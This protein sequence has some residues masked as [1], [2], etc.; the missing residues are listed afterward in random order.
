MSL[1]N[2]TKRRSLFAMGLLALVVH[3]V[4]DGVI[5]G[6]DRRHL[7]GLMAT[8]GVLTGNVHIFSTG[9]VEPNH[10][11]DSGSNLLV[12][13]DLEVQG[14]GW[15][16]G[17]LTVKGIADGGRTNYDLK[18]GDTDGSPTYG[19]IQM[20]NASI[21]RT[22]HTDGIDLDGAVLIRNIAGPVTSEIEFIFAESTGSTCRFALPKS[23]VGNA[24]YNPRSLLIAGPAPADTDFVKV[25]YWRTNN[26]IFHNIDC[27]TTGVGADLGV[28]NDLEVEGD[29]FTDSLLESTPGAGIES[30]KIKLTSI[31]GY[32]VKLTNKSGA[33]SVAGDV[34]QVAAATADAVDIT[35]AGN[36]F[37]VG[38]FLDS[39]VADGSEAWV[40]IA[41]IADVHMD[42][43]GT[44]IQDR[45]IT[46][47]TPGRGDASNNPAVAEHFQEIGHALET[48]GANG[49]AR[50]I[51]HFL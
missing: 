31:G 42:A 30:N 37:P 35:D 5:A 25:T 47:A 20:G 2:A 45:I 44:T 17:V 13:G 40:V 10:I 1:E 4:P 38:V 23:G 49:N 19:M 6:L 8:Q 22:S 18:V 34:V 28:Q 50:C 48:V 39:G 9:I 36:L 24:T 29:I 16:E 43:G 21:G 3:P 41:G 11:A 46:S 14:A 51:I 7:L 15:V 26:N 32:A 27:D 12:A 33:N